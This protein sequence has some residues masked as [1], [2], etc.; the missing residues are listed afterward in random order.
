VGF[1]VEKVEVGQ[2][3]IRI[4]RFPLPI[5]ILPNAPYPSSSGAGTVGQVVVDVPR[6]LSLTP[7]HETK[8]KK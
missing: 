2:V 8:K 4:P 1:D 6:G 5:L 7:P 3:F